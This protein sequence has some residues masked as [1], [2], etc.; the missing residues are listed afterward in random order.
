[1]LAGKKSGIPSWLTTEH[2]TLVS[3]RTFCSQKIGSN[4]QSWDTGGYTYSS[5]IEAGSGNSDW[6]GTAVS[7][8]LLQSTLMPDS[9]VLHVHWEGHG[10]T[11]DPAD[12]LVEAAAAGTLLM[13]IKNNPKKKQIPSAW[14]WG[15]QSR[16][17]EFTIPGGSGIR[18]IGPVV[19][20]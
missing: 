3:V 4:G 9:T 11:G 17:L 12:L 20:L 18:T 5:V 8:A 15:C 6:P 13:Q 2:T 10:E 16:R 1:M 19:Q 7:P 14:L